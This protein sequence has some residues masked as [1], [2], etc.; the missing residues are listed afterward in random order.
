[1]RLTIFWRIIL[2]QASLVALTI[3]INIYAVS[4]LHELTR[5][6]QGILSTDAATIE[7]AKRLLRL[8]FTQRRSAEKFVLL[9]DKAFYDQFL[10]TNHSLE[11]SLG[12]LTA[13][14]PGLAEQEVLRRPAG[15]LCRESRAADL[16]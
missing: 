14:A 5:L 12:K 10:E 6:S 7:E 8:M 13:S 11:E 9:Q 16:T 3:V 2:A 1:V 15:P 4:Q